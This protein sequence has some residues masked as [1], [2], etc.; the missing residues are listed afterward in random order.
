MGCKNSKITPY[1]ELVHE[2]CGKLKEMDFK[3]IPRIQNEFAD[4]L[5]TVSSRIQHPDQ[6]YI[7][8]LEISLKEKPEHCAHIKEDPDRK[9]W[10]YH[11]KSWALYVGRSNPDP[12]SYDSCCLMD[13]LSN[14]ILQLAAE[15]KINKDEI[16]SFN[17]PSYTTYEEDIKKIIQMEGSF[18]LERLE[19]F[20]SDMVAIEKPNGKHFEDSAKLVVKTIRAVTEVMLASHFGN[21]II[22]YLFDIYIMH[23]TEYLSMGNTIKFCNI[24]LCL[25]KK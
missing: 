24:S 4:A 11:I 23:V 1:M 16:V 15:G 2:L 19:T 21:S 6:S 18:N 20:E 7:D 9:T 5:A 3:H 22:D 17:M 10:Y 13:L 14:S 25:Q 12:R 8:P